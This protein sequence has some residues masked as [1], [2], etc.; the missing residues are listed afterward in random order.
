MKKFLSII[1][2]FAL[3][4]G[5]AISLASCGNKDADKGSDT[6]PKS[7]PD[8]CVTAL[9]N[10]GFAVDTTSREEEISN[11]CGVSGI[12]T[13]VLATGKNAD[14]EME[15]VYVFYFED[16]DALD[17]G[18]DELNELFEEWMA[19][20][21]EGGVEI[22]TGKSG[23]MAWIG[24]ELAVKAASGK[25]VDGIVG[26]GTGNKYPEEDNNEDN[27]EDQDNTNNGT[28]TGNGENQNAVSIFENYEACKAALVNSEFLVEDMP[29]EWFI[30]MYGL[31]GLEA[32]FGAAGETADGKIESLYVF[33]F[34]SSE[35]MAAADDALTALFDE[36]L[37]DTT[38]AASAVTS[39]KIGK[40]A[41]IGSALAIE[42]ASGVKIDG[43]TNPEAGYDE[44][45]E[46]MKDN[47]SGESSSESNNNGDNEV[48]AGGSFD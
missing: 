44:G 42:A 40:V 37:S 11:I 34:E 46:G 36:M 20:T 15:I 25:R 5:C 2:A 17:S 27:N 10:S 1:L 38:G 47:G 32:G 7:D 43:I 18:I 30:E 39:G 22:I 21:E 3:L 35:A 31:V 16:K 12:A 23:N 14:G 6:K 41:W 28:D 19:D 26:A 24:T 13:V 45:D 8:A 9:R 48:D 4:L 33:V 29:V